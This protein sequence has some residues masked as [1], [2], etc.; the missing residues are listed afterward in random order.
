MITTEEKKEKLILVGIA[1]DDVDAAVASLEELAQLADTAGAEVLELF[2]QS[3]EHPHPGTYLGSGKLEELKERIRELEADAVICDDELTPAQMRN[4]ADILDTKVLDRSLLILDIFAGRAATKE[5]KIQIELAQLRYRATR[6]TGKGT[7]LSRLGG[8]IGTRGPG[9]SK[10]ESDRRAIHTRISQLKADLAEVVRHREQ[11]R[12]KRQKSQVPVIAVV[13]YTNAGK[14]TLL[15]K[16]TGADILAEDKL[17]ATLDPTTRSLALPGGETVL[18]TD[19]VGFIRKLPHHLIDAFK[20]TLEESRYADVILHVVDA[21]NPQ[22]KQQMETVYATLKDLQVENKPVITVFN[23]C[24][25]P[26]GDALLYDAVA[27]ETLRISALTG[28]GLERL[29]EVLS[30]VLK[31]QKIYID[32]V[33][34]YQEAGTVGQI[35]KYGSVIAEEYEENGIHIKAYV[36]K[37]L[38]LKE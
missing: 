5:G 34:S 29:T 16:L 3:R 24:D 4:M 15:N 2:V 14:S 27:D 21:S 20:S 26:L 8:G 37:A 22:F 35:R 32:R 23:K 18:L 25:R 36:P 7:A 1:E 9:E 11:Q 10:L 6:L 28:E 12:E 30:E 31:A 17:F 13:G 19:T 33:F 38:G